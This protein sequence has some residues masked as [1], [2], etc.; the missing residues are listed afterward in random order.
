MNDY[1]C[2][3]VCVCSKLYGTRATTCE[4]QNEIT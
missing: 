1:M 3:S 4:L 2:V